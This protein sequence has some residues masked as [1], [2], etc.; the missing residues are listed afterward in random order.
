M[1]VPFKKNMCIFYI[2]RFSFYRIISSRLDLWKWRT[3]CLNEI[4][5]EEICSHTVVEWSRQLEMKKVNERVLLS[6]RR[7]L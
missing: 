2:Y 3:S 4:N 1:T 5:D 7:G 6:H